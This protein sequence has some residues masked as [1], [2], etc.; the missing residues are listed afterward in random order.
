MLEN[1][2]KHLSAAMN[3]LKANTKQNTVSVFG[4]SHSVLSVPYQQPTVEYFRIG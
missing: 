1:D 4:S 2:K 3:Q